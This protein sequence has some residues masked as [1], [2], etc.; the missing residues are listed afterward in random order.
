MEKLSFRVSSGLKNI[1][2]RELITDKIIAVFEIVKNSYDAGASRVDI[3]FND[4]QKDNSSIV[5]SDNGC[6]MT[7]NDIINKWLFVAYSE[8]KYNRSS[9][10][11]NI[12]KKRTY[13]GAKGVGRFSCDRLGDSLNLYSKQKIENHSNL[14]TVNWNDFEKMHKKI[15]RKLLC[16]IVNRQAYLVDIVVVQH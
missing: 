3:S 2:G 10:V 4:M 1:I 7:K 13:A 14:L 12:S 6:G 9:Y 5:I 16:I 15:S 11:E 8:K